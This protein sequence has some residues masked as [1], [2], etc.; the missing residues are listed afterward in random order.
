MIDR[1]AVSGGSPTD[2]PIS[3]RAVLIGIPAVFALATGARSGSIGFGHIPTEIEVPPL[4]EANGVAPGDLVDVRVL[5]TEAD[6]TDDGYIPLEYEWSPDGA[7]SKLEVAPRREYLLI[8]AG[9]LWTESITLSIPENPD[10]CEYFVLTAFATVPNPP[11]PVRKV[12]R[13][14]AT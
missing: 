7:V 13:R 4:V 1:E 9:S 8:A 2:P 10:N 11:P 5:V 6:D 3:R 14:R 12:L